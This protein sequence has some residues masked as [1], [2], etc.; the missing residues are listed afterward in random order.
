MNADPPLPLNAWLRYDLVRTVLGELDS[1]VSSVLE[2]GA[3]EGAFGARLARHYDYVGVEPDALSCSRAAE[4]LGRIGRGRMICGDVSVVGPEAAF[5][6]LC[7][8]EV[9]E[10]LEDDTAALSDWR[11]RLRRG[12]WL[13]LSVPARP[14]RFGPHDRIVG[15]YRRYDTALL[16]QV[17]LDSGFVDPVVLSFGFPIGYALEAA[18][19]TI[20]RL[21]TSRK[22]ATMSDQTAM[23]GR[24]LQPPDQVAWLTAAASAPFRLLQRPFM[25]TGLGTGLVALARRPG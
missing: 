16:E 1:E 9:L 18:R 5:D 6:L 14:D 11:T 23:S 24:W 10:H 20:A 12:G 22:S 25:R 21:A 13:L 15:H 19:N 17:I 2:V 4:R 8:F 7:S 3:G